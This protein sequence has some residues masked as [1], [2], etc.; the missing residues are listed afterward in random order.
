VEPR[1]SFSLSQPPGHGYLALKGEVPLIGDAGFATL[2][3]VRVGGRQIAEQTLSVGRFEV[4]AP[5]N[6]GGAAGAAAELGA[7]MSPGPRQIELEFSHAQQLPGGDGR[8]VAA[9]LTFAGFVPEPQPPA[10]LE[11]FP[12]D[13]KR[14]QVNATGVSEDGWLEQAASFQLTQPPDGETLTVAGMVPKIGDG[15]G[16]TTDVVVT[17]DGQEVARKTAGLDRFTIDAVVPPPAS[18]PPGAGG[19]VRLVGIT[20]SRVQTLPAPDGRAVGAKLLS[21][22]FVTPAD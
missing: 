10:G 15:D 13:L 9:R 4:A 20:F 5:L 21:T 7:A 1:T 6:P 8:G 11:Q 14:P 22:R 3:R 17:V 12:N 16:F 2:M 18:P 19:A